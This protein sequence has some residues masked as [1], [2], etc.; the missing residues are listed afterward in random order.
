MSDEVITPMQGSRIRENSGMRLKSYDFSYVRAICALA[1]LL[2]GPAGFSFA[3]PPQVYKAARI[4]TG[5][6]A[7]INDGVLVVEDGKIAAV[8]PRD[9]ISIP[10]DAQVHNLGSAVLIP[11]LVIAETTLGESGRDDERTL[12]PEIKAVDGFD[13]YSPFKGPLSGGVTTVQIAPGSHRLMPGQG[14]VVK[15]AGPDPALRT[16]R[17][18]ESLRI[19]LGDSYKNPPRIF[20]PPV[21]ATSVERPLEPTRRQLAGS[22]PAASAGLRALFRAAEEQAKS[23]ATR[24]AR[25][26]ALAAISPFLQ[27]NRRVRI[28]A[29]TT[30]DISAALALAR[31]FHLRVLLVD[32]AQLEPFRDRLDSWRDVVAGVIL[33]SEP[34]PRFVGDGPATEK[35][36][37][38]Q[39]DPWEVA[40]DLAAAGH[41]IAIRP[42]LDADLADTLFVAGLYQTAGFTPD[43]V[44]RMLTAIPAE[45]LGVS[46]RVGSLA[47][48]KDADFVVLDSD[49]FAL[50]SRVQS[51]YIEG[52]QVFTAK[53][54]PRST[55]VRAG[56]I[57]TGTGAVLT[58]G[59][60]LVEGSKLSRI[61]RDVSAPA[62][63][64]VR[65]FENAV[66]VPGFIDLESGLGVGG[67]L[68]SPVALNVSLGARLVANDPA[69][70]VARQ[71]G[72]TSVLLAST[73]AGPGPVV[74][75]KLTDKPRVIREPVAIRFTISG[76]LTTQAESL[77]AVLLLGQSYAQNWARYEVALAEYE[78][79]K[80]EYDKKKLEFDAAKAKTTAAKPAEDSKPA[81][82]KVEA[83]P[84]APKAPQAPE[85]P[86][87]V[88]NREPYR[89]L[90]AGKIPALVEARRADAI[91]LAVK[92]FRDEFKVRTVLLGADDAFRLADLLATK[93]VAVAVGPDMMRTVDRQPINL[94][95]ILATR[96]V[97][98]GFQSKATTGVKVL[99]LAVQYAVQHGLGA[100]DALAGLTAWPARLLSLD[101]QVGIL[102]PG[103]DADLVV[104][105]G[106]PFETATRVLAVMIDGQWVYQEE[107]K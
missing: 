103:A 31:D 75:F 82:K 9:R 62:D 40:R 101:K 68:S 86:A 56:R 93:Q 91:Q 37:P 106:P 94:A 49:P 99:P 44:L 13:F 32:P 28:T 51:V 81:D 6:D 102:A 4:W 16:L 26:I 12:T 60:L 30:A 19:M 21:R 53:A 59:S 67:P 52:K 78:K 33:G 104:L 34:N 22:L 71:G 2:A 105:S 79:K 80:Q 84:E 57:Y 95:Q 98:I 25:D 90:F 27:P 100:D 39:R 61:G 5:Q 45:I 17:E 41:K 20:D 58:P 107:L 10:A 63:A 24:S 3:G 92:L 14:A 43:Q 85:K 1:L 54:S 69:Y 15:L 50:H 42:S 46:D 77:R 87:V 7:V 18:S 89:A 66:V 65:R 76:N 36:E 74:A 70:A 96:N 64:Q 55:V 38:P 83:A 29:P 97:P 47:K 11:G 73:N 8:G 88:E 48:G 23:T 35:D 72:V